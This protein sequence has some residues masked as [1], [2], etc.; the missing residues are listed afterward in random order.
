MNPPCFSHPTFP[1]TAGGAQHRECP[2]PES[3]GGIHL[4]GMKLVPDWI[5]VA[6]IDLRSLLVQSEA[7]LE[8][9]V[10]ADKQW[11][12]KIA[13]A[14]DVEMAVCIEI[15]QKLR[16]Q[17]P[18]ESADRRQGSLPLGYRID[19]E[20]LPGHLREFIKDKIR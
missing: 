8:N 17:Y 19:G 16:K 9:K 13:L 14:T 1:A 20:Q 5:A 6:R 15:L 7:Q 11:A 2:V 18:Q 4:G 12:G 10:S 3:E